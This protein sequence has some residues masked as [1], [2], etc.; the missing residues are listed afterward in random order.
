MTTDSVSQ[1]RPR[2]A[3][4]DIGSNSI[5][6]V[7]AEADGE[8]GYRVLDEEREMTRL[9][10][11]LEE[12]GRLLPESMEHS[13]EAIGKMK[14]IAEGFRV[15]Q[16]RAIATSAVRDAA[17][18]AE[19]CQEARRRHGLD[20]EIISPQ[21]EARLAFESAARNFNLEGRSTAI[22]DIGGGSLEVILT[23]GPVIEQVH[24]LPL[25][26]VRLT[27]RFCLSDPLRPKHRKALLAE[28]DD[29]LKEHLRKP[30]FKAEVMIG[31]GGTFAAL[32]DM[33]RCQREGRAGSVHGYAITDSELTA[34]L[35]KLLETPLEARRQIPGLSPQRADI[36]VAGAAVVARL[37][38]RLET[39]KI[40]V[41]ERGIRD[42][43]LLSML[44]ALPGRSGLVRPQP[45]KDRMEWVR[46]FARKC[47]SHE[48]HCEQVA[49]L[50]LQIFDSLQPAFELSSENREILLAGT[51]LHDIGY[52]IGHAKHHKHA[53]HLIM[54]SG[55]PGF[56]AREIELIANLARYHRR[57]EPRKSHENFARLDKKD[58]RLVRQLSGIL[59]VAD[60]LDRAHTQC[61]RA[62]GC[63]VG[64]KTVR[65]V[66]E[67]ATD[68]QV[69]IWY[70]QAKADLFETAFG[71]RLEIVWNGAAAA[72][73]AGKRKR[74]PLE[75]TAVGA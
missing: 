35:E 55:L 10:K 40:L 34:L 48:P 9:G 62:T 38:Q 57:A 31:S 70:A 66:V 39:R 21:H 56:S 53:Y 28:I 46:N 6:L 63:A 37:A 3:A 61:V 18:G 32:G 67:S 45:P 65:L 5:R 49:R 72:P 47:H 73:P 1:D 19:F 17:N 33:V 59:R 64:P 23:A 29:A 51:L 54:H 68:P 52:L 69:E 13:L 2:L 27:E 25:G 43:L 16:L 12:T 60:G 42:G 44:A 4:I 41:N 58:R 14:A 75:G 22:A 50:A 8:Q 30:R 71:R 20:I 74:A 11:G 26:A 7:V 24:S 36:I 15:G